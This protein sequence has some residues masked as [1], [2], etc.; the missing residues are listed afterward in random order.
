MNTLGL[1]RF[2][3]AVATAMLLLCTP[4]FADTAAPAREGTGDEKQ[5][6]AA[7][8]AGKVYEGMPAADLRALIGKPDI[9]KPVETKKGHAEVWIY[10]RLKRSTTDTITVGNKPI[11]TR[12][13]RGDEYVDVV[14]GQEPI[15]KKQLTDVYEVAS[16]LIVN[17]QF[18]LCK[19]TEET[20]QSFQ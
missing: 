20:E 9:I 19:N 4:L 3:A 5:E 10:R 11:T 15:I 2:P 18:I 6:P 8:P 7:H 16:F 1:P 13:K 12:Q 14:I 17:D